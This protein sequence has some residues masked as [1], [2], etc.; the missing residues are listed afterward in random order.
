MGGG[1]EQQSA[2]REQATDG[3][4]PPPPS[5]TVNLSA[6]PTSLQSGGSSQLSWSS[7]NA[8]SCTASG[9]WTG[10]K[11]TSGNQTVGPLS[12]TTTFTLSCT[13]SGGTAQRSVTVTVTSTT[14]PPTVSLSANPTSVQSGGTS[15][16][17][18]S[19]TNATSCTASGA[20]NG[21]A[22]SPSLRIAA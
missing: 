7:T 16:L 22:S 8:S 1:V 13:G 12:S 14:P 6:D 17:T 10:S 11:Q 5:P 15:T 21:T 20:W 4:T 18:W 3:G 2:G 19:S 9:G